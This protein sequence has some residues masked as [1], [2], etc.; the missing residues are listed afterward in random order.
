MGEYI[1]ISE[2]R[3]HHILGVARKAYSIAKNMGFSEEFARKCF[4]LGWIH[5]VGYEFVTDS[6]DHS[7]QSASLLDMLGDYI[8]PEGY[9]RDSIKP[10]IRVIIE[11]SIRAIA[12]HGSFVQDMTEEYKILNMA[13]LQVDN[14]GNEVSVEERLE[15][16]KERYGEYSKEYLDACEIA[17]RVGLTETNIARGKVC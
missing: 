5:D 12:C 2:N 8:Y 15:D 17:F 11:R 14:E 4:M 7:I 9:R 6:P 1:G 3:L 16:I 10:G 13:D